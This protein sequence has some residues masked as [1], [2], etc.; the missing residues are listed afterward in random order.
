MK[1]SLRYL[2]SLVNGF[3]KPLNVADIIFI[4]IKDEIVSVGLKGKRYPLRNFRSLDGLMQRLDQR[5]FF[6]ANRNTII[7]IDKISKISVFSA[8]SC[9]IEMSDGIDIKLSRRR[10]SMLMRVLGWK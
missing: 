9:S 7:Q 6:R 10:M 2:P 8:K 1:E 3:I 4:E 5:C